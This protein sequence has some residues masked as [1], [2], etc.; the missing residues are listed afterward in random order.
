MFFKSISDLN[1]DIILN[2]HRI[3]K[4]IDLV[5]GVP[6]SG[7]LV[8]NII[9]LHLNV[10]LA[11]LD[12]FIEG[13]V[14]QSGITRRPNDYDN[15]VKK[16]KKVLIVEDSV[17]SG[18]SIQNAKNK[19][20]NINRNDIDVIFF[21]AYIAP[22]KESL[23]D[24]YLEICDLPRV[25]EWNIMHHGVVER[26]CFDLDGVLCIDPTESDDDDGEIY[27]SFLRQVKPLFV[28]TKEIGNIVT[29]R[30]EKYREETEE[31]LK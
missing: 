23:V 13:K 30:L 24:M 18:E 11:D 9:A 22:G 8:A 6:R 26:S 5:V 16:Q 1:R 15:K 20:L 28:P 10:P 19:I 14:F 17:L 3:P 12:G 7:L 2:L 27:K 29:C 21:A 31:W 25:F 4:D